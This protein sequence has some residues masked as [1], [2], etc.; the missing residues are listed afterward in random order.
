M[1]DLVHLGW[2]RWPWTSVVKRALESKYNS[3]VRHV[4]KQSLA[5]ALWNLFA[6]FPVHPCTMS[7]P[8]DELINLL[9]SLLMGSLYFYPL[10]TYLTFLFIFLRR[11]DYLYSHL[12]PKHH[13]RKSI[14]ALT[15]IRS[16]LSAPFAPL[17]SAQAPSGQSG[18]T[19][20]LG[21]AWRIDNG[22]GLKR[23]EAA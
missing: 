22:S 6:A 3:K 5:T 8:H 13:I 16:S 9:H 7:T 14:W 21:S 23:L 1:L 20:W 18:H 17:D 2:P 12:L 15:L 4:L 10:L 11:L 19:T